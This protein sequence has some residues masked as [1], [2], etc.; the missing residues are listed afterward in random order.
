MH[1]ATVKFPGMCLVLKMFKIQRQKDC[2]DDTFYFGPLKVMHSNKSLR[3][4]TMC[5]QAQ[6]VVF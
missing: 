5:W 1:Q 6:L 3:W 2:Q 4:D